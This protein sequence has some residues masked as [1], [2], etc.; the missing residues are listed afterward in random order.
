MNQINENN[1]SD[2]HDEKSATPQGTSR[3]RRRF[4]SGSLSAAPV[5][6]ALQSSSALAT[7]CRTPSRMMSGNLSNHGD[8]STCMAGRSPG[9]LKKPESFSTWGV[10]S[11][12]LQK[13]FSS[14]ARWED[15]T[16]TDPPLIGTFKYSAPPIPT[17]S[18]RLKPDALGNG[19]FG[20]SFVATFGQRRGL[21][22]VLPSPKL[23]NTVPTVNA[24]RDLSFWEI[25]AYPA[26][27]VGV[28]PVTVQL[29][30][31]C[32]AAYINAL[33]ATGSNFYPIT[34]QQAIHMWQDGTMGGYCAISSC[35]TSVSWTA[36]EIIDY[37]KSTFDGQFIDY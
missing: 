15:N 33:K 4:V 20:A 17:G 7:N 3:T 28:D 8:K 34:P 27:Q 16:P 24:A 18:F 12:T 5:L 25:L 37:I 19:D 9:Y 11:P 6:L 30:R 36:A 29:A 35:S 13:R 21:V 14:P 10:D 2:R 26:E 22:N 31:H 23:D 1:D 32:I